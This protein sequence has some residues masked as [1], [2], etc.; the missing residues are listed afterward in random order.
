[1]DLGYLIIF[2]YFIPRKCKGSH[3]S[4]SDLSYLMVYVQ[5]GI[6]P[7]ITNLS[8]ILPWSLLKTRHI[9]NRPSLQQ[10]VGTVIVKIIKLHIYFVVKKRYIKGKIPFH[11]NFPSKGGL[12][13]PS[14]NET[15]HPICRTRTT[16]S[17]AVSGTTSKRWSVEK[18]RATCIIISCFTDRC[19]E[20]KAVYRVLELIWIVWFICYIPRHTDR[21]KKTISMPLGKLLTS[22][23]TKICFNRVSTIKR[24]NAS[25]YIHLCSK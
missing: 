12:S 1:M 25:T 20:L 14:F 19:S 22:C 3:P 13:Q 2:K 17:P 24:I 21:G 4:H 18:S 10:N 9:R 6:K 11:F 7:F 16:Y 5:T 8:K 23:N 15:I